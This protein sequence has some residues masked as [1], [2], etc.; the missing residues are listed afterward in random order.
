MNKHQR[1]KSRFVKMHIKLS[2]IFTGRRPSYK[3]AKR[4][5]R[6]YE[7]YVKAWKSP[8]SFEKP[9]LLGTQASVYIIDETP[10]EATPMW[11]K[12]NPEFERRY[13]G[14][15]VGLEEGGVDA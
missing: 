3:E 6:A 1:A 10:V 7:R 11:P 9:Q 15:F 8:V 14:K 4:E 12:E 2:E 5:V 13:M